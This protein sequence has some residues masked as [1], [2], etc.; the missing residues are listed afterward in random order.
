MK[1]L[2]FVVLCMFS[3]SALASDA[4]SSVPTTS[5]VT[6]V[7]KTKNHTHSHHHKDKKVV[8]K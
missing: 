3:L 1:K 4:A 7:A 5:T 6:K 8:K 2:L